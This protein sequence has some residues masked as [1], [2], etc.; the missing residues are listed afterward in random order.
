MG[1]NP[2]PNPIEFNGKTP[3]QHKSQIRCQFIITEIHN[4]TGP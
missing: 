4:L 1:P 3:T 2:D